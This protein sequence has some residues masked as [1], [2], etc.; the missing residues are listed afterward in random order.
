[1]TTASSYEDGDMY[2]LVN[3]RR[4]GGV[5]HPAAP[6]AVTGE[7]CGE[8]D[9]Y[10]I[11]GSEDWEHWIGVRNKRDSVTSDVYWNIDASDCDEVKVLHLDAAGLIHS[12]EQN[13][14]LLV[15]VTEDTVYYAL[16]RDGDYRWIGELPDPVPVEWCCYEEK[17][18]YTDN[19]EDNP[20]KKGKELN[21]E[22]LAMISESRIA[23]NQYTG[24]Y[25]YIINKPVGSDDLLSL[26]TSLRSHVNEMRTELGRNYSDVTDSSIPGSFRGL[27]FDAFFVR[28]AYRLYDGTNMK[29]SPPILIMSSSELRRSVSVTSGWGFIPEKGQV[30]YGFWAN[31][32]RMFMFGYVP[33]IKYDL[34]PLSGY[35][36]IIKGID[37]FMS[38]MLDIT[39]V[40]K[41]TEL[42]RLFPFTFP[43]YID[44]NVEISER[45]DVSVFKDPDL[46]GIED[47]SSFYLV[48]S[49]DAGESTGG[50][51]VPFPEKTDRDTILNIA[52]L[53]NKRQ[54][55]DDTVSIHRTGGKKSYFYNGRFHLANLKTDCF[56]G[57]SRR[58][59]SWD[60]PGLAGT[61]KYNGGPPITYSTPMWERGTEF[62]V[63][64]EIDNGGVRGR[65]YS[66]SVLSEDFV[67]GIHSA[68]ISYPDA[69]ARRMTVYAKYPSGG[70]ERLRSF[71]LKEHAFLNLA[72][73]LNSDLKPIYIPPYGTPVAD[74]D[75][76]KGF[77]YESRNELMVSETNNPFRTRNVDVLR[78]GDGSILAMGTFAM[79]TGEWNYGSFPLYVFTDAGV[80]SLR[81]GEGDVAYSAVTQ[82]VSLDV[83]VSDVICETP[84][85]IAF[86]TKRGVCLIGGAGV[87]YLSGPVEEE[88]AGLYFQRV[89]LF[90][91][92]VLADYGRESFAGYL[93]GLTGMIYN[94]YRRELVMM[95][96]G[97]D[98]N[99]VFCA[100]DRSFYVCTERIRHA[101]SGSIPAMKVVC[102]RKVLDFSREEGDTHVSFITRP[103]RYGSP[104]VKGMERMVMRA[105]IY[106]LKGVGGGEAP[107]LMVHYSDDGR[108]FAAGAG[109]T[110]CEGNHRD[111][112]PGMVGRMKFRQY[113]FSFAG[114]CG[115]D[116]V[117]ECLESEVEVAY[118]GT[119]MR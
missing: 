46:N 52:A 64:T 69:R 84:G 74:I 77:S 5:L 45:V 114:L 34:S 29:L 65:V 66:P 10:F 116:T 56:R 12:V 96:A 19:D 54:L 99:W 118:D 51:Y 117:L 39:G 106:G 100:D 14:N 35:E 103:L 79:G 86:V 85:G 67:A 31:L 15:F 47:M 49:L 59:F 30:D 37:I 28:Y 21:I 16:F 48:K 92:G 73:Y 97:R 109:L 40:D 7:L 18:Y 32:G 4:K 38:P 75:V 107:V 80:Y 61:Y 20:D 111:L 91:D 105:V 115:P 110:V 6:H 1:M 42:S 13:G 90:T 11:H 89:P 108:N 98:Y 26:E 41:I 27:F 57:F 58:F 25:G 104:D 22:T 33:G 50:D 55:A 71:D 102:G 78:A 3:L 44:L 36:D 62:I 83:P 60:K 112:D 24:K 72:Y 2:S 9:I 70:T 68:M 8:Y 23:E 93:E 95:N 17:E 119:K 88:P 87:S 82:P 76:S 63:E 113:V 43:G 53:V 94:H 101:V 81:T